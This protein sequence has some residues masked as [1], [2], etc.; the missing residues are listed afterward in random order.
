MS[1]ELAPS[2]ANGRSLSASPALL[3]EAVKRRGLDEFQ[4]STLCNSL[5]PGARPESVLLVVDYCRARKLDPLKKPCHIVPME[6]RDSKTGTT[7]WRDVVLPGIYEH[8]T[9]AQRTGLYLGHSFPSWG[10]ELEHKGVK[11]FEYCELVVYRWHEATKQRIEF[12]VRVY[13]REAVTLTRDGRPNSRWTRAPLQMLLKCAEAAGLREAFPDEIGGEMTAE[14]MDGRT[15]DE[16]AIEATAVVLPDKPK[17]FEEWLSS[18]Q[19]VADKG[20][21]AL[22]AAWRQS[23]AAC[24]EYLE[25]ADPSL[26]NAI[27]ARANAVDAASTPATPAATT[28]PPTEEPKGAA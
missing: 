20:V 17:Q 9:T 13:F 21:S 25:K 8:R 19:N 1:S 23:P 2:V 14:E 12:P 15:L 22:K 5:F 6:V 26:W 18:L 10:P 4:W 28:T 24:R 3:A 7:E 27:K 16:S 11:C